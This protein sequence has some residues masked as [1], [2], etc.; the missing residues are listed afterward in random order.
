MT[1]K[2][3]NVSEGLEPCPFC[4]GEALC[5]ATDVDDANAEPEDQMPTAWGVTCS[6]AAFV[7][8]WATEAEAIAAWNARA[9]LSPPLPSPEVEREDEWP[10]RAIRIA[11]ALEHE[12]MSERGG[13]LWCRLC[14]TDTGEDG[15][16]HAGHCV[17]CNDDPGAER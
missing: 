9:T 3:T 2:A 13:T 17:L 11:E 7:G 15:Q 6:C 5:A 1:T 8:P 4:G 16:G 12:V 14:S 10:E